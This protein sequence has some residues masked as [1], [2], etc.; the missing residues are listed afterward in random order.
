V[1]TRWLPKTSLGLASGDF[2]LGRAHG[3]GKMSGDGRKR[4][5]PRKVIPC[6]VLTPHGFC[7]LPQKRFRRCEYHVE[8]LKADDLYL[9]AV[10]MHAAERKIFLDILDREQKTRKPWAYTNDTGANEPSLIEAE[11]AKDRAKKK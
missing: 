5:K 6:G 3:V 10:R 8:C 9:T 4:R 7:D 2:Q 11:E 1:R